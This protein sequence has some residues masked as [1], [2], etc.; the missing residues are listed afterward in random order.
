MKPIFFSTKED[1]R[2]WL[3]QHHAI[4]SEVLVGFYRRNT[5]KAAMTYSEALDQSL[6]FGWID[7]VRG[8]AGANGFTIR[9][10]PRK[11]N[12]SWSRANVTRVEALIEQSL[13]EPTGLAAFQRRAS[14]SGVSVSDDP[15]L[16]RLSAADEES[17]RSNTRAW[18]WFESQAP[19]YQRT[20]ARWVN[21]AKKHETRQRRLS[22]LIA[23]A[24]LGRKIKPLRR[25]G[26][27]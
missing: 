19:G 8:K 16:L 15:D 17:F 11:P 14:R 3:A 23:D 25:S 1:F 5:K 27:E 7:G 12:S 10:T 22:E 21:S 6:C 18:S 2:S 13:M 4:S 9:F 24:A 20:A 26:D